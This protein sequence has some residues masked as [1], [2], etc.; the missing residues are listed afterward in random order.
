MEKAAVWWPFPFPP[1]YAPAHPTPTACKPRRSDRASMDLH[2]L[3]V[4][5][6]TAVLYPLWLLAGFYDY[7]C[8]RRTDIE[9]TSGAAESRYH[10]AQFA[11][12][13]V[14]LVCAAL[15]EVTPLV[16]T[17]LVLFVLMHTVLGVADVAY[18]QDRRYIS[19]LE[20]FVHGFMSVLPVVAVGLVGIIHSSDILSSPWALRPK[21]APIPWRQMGLLVG[22]YF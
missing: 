12:L 16:F 20:Q 11:S 18:T 4:G 2:A 14:P 6:L 17:I 21:D 1:S 9:R 5:F 19:P 22:S 10:L 15:L 3:L 7:I 8:H 13:A